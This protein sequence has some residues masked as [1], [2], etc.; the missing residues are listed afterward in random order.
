LRSTGSTALKSHVLTQGGETKVYRSKPLIWT[1]VG[2]SLAVAAA[3]WLGLDHWRSRSMI[4]QGAVIR[5][6]TEPQ[7]ERPISDVVIT[8]SD[9]ALSASA[10]SDAHGYFRLV[11]PERVWS[12]QPMMLKFRHPEFRPLDLSLQTGLHS[13]TGQ[14]QIAAMTPV[15]PTTPEPAVI[16]DQ[17]PVKDQ[18][19]SNIRI[20]Y[21]VN[22]QTEQNFGSVVKTFQAVNAGNVPCDHASP[23]SPDGKWKASIGSISLDAGPDSEFRDV[24]VSCIAGPCPFT[25][26]DSNG[27]EHGGRSITANVLNWSGTTTFLLE[28]EV[29]HTA[30]SSEV[31]ESYP[32]VFGR[33]LNF[34][35]PPTEEGVS[36]EA[37]LAGS[38]MV[39]PLGPNPSLSW[40]NCVETANAGDKTTTAY[41]CELKPGYRF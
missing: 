41:R 31:R 6:D 24:R 22:S 33:V 28:A 3:L 1:L 19:V 18:V 16:K 10:T 21:T 37:D 40:A 39:F 23:C 32:V 5:Q 4:I 35:L 20:R 38:P 34:S 26:I 29:F 8:A 2:L 12:G 14:L 30:I 11:F 25:R 15:D 36:I 27:Y 17:V 7:R 9:G 13:T